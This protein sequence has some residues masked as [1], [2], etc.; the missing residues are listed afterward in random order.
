MLVSLMEAA[1]R[2]DS[3]TG[4]QMAYL[5]EWAPRSH[6]DLELRVPDVLPRPGAGACE[7]HGL[8]AIDAAGRLEADVAYIDPPYNQHSYLGNYHIWESLVRWDKPGVYGVAC[9]RDDCRLR[10]SPFNSRREALGAFTRLIS[11][12]R[13]RSII[14]SFSD[15]GHLSR[16][17]VE[18]VLAAR[19]RVSTLPIDYK[20]YV[21]AQIGIHNP[22]GEKVGDPG[23]A[24]NTEYLFVVR[25][26]DDRGTSV[27]ASDLV[28][29]YIP[30]QSAV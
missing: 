29:R 9:K 22:R 20:R 19:G 7:A 28:Q 27:D 6:K 16:G 26:S 2:V 14:V 25:V 4:V 11:A 13:A 10:K 15:E 5:K 30:E 23:P 8:D 18:M 3:T 24:R 21:G 1:D 12:V 17:D